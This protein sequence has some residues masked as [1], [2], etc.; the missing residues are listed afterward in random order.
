MLKISPMRTLLIALIFSMSLAGCAITSVD[1]RRMALRSDEFQAYVE[2]VFRRQN[3]LSTALA[4]VIDAEPSDSARL[5][6]LEDVE[7]D[8]LRSCSGLNEIARAR[9]DDE[10]V[11]GLAALKRA[12][13]AP[14][15]ERAADRADEALATE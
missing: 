13:Q 3:E 2:A 1:G 10:D 6:R 14:A 15:C 12:R 11:G 5:G 4:L 9:R 8:L 7:L